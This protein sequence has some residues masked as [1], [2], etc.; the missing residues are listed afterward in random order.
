M[1]TP[2]PASSSREVV[3]VE[4]QSSAGWGCSVC[5]WMFHPS[6]P[7]IGKTID[8]MTRNFQMQLSQEFGSHEC[9]QHPRV[10]AETASM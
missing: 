10:K 5:A 9:A 8:E 6:G 3:W 7:P 2:G 1:L 4:R